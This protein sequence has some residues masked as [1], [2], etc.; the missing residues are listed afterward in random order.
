MR[1]SQSNKRVF[2]SFCLHIIGLLLC[3]IPP[4]AC[5]L[6]YFPLWRYS[7][8]KTAS[9]GVLLLILLSCIPLFKLFKK[10]FN[11]PASYVIWILL[12]VIFFLLSKIADEMV[13]ISFYGSLGNLLGAIC[14]YTSKR[15][16]KKNEN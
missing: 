2:G 8:E 16:N 6:A 15:M 11:S 10:R 3:I 12:F 4:I 13:V 7:S 14:F 5:T 9:G 1:N